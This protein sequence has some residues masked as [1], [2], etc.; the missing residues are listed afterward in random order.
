MNFYKFEPERKTPFAPKFE[1]VL[2]E[3][4]VDVD[5]DNLRDTILAKEH[6]IISENEYES[7]WG[8]GLGKQSMTSR[9]SS[10]NLLFWDE[11]SKLK[12][13]IKKYHDGIMERMSLKK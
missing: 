9:S 6:E 11:A 13:T 4:I 7:D 12:T 3:D 5:F 2:M 8:T 10:Y 1:I